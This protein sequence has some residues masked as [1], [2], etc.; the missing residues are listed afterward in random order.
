M[1]SLEKTLIVTVKS[2]NFIKSLYWFVFLEWAQLTFTG[3]T[4][5]EMSASTGELRA[6]KP[7]PPGKLKALW[8]TGLTILKNKFKHKETFQSIFQKHSNRW[9]WFSWP[10]IPE[11]SKKGQSLNSFNVRGDRRAFCLTHI[12]LTPLIRIRSS[13][14]T[15]VRSRAPFTESKSYWGQTL[16]SGSWTDTLKRWNIIK[17]SACQMPNDRCQPSGLWGYKD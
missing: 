4:G 17:G 16:Q 12:L 11:T 2:V 7:R 10:H 6:K 9:W 14:E 15:C 5:N 13:R 3:A 1:T 8:K